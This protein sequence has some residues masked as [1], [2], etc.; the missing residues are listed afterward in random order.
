M[1]YAQTAEEQLQESI[2]SQLEKLDLSAIENYISSLPNIGDGLYKGSFLENIKE[3]INGSKQLDF[4]S[5]F[6]Y[7]INLI[8]DDLLKYVPIF[9]VI[10]AICIVCSLLTGFSPDKNGEKINKVIYFACFAVVAIIIFSVFKD[11]LSLALGILDGIKNQM[12]LVFPILLTLITS[13][14]SVVTVSTF[15]PAVALLSSSIVS[16]ISSVVL[17][18]FLFTFV[19]NIVGHMSDTVKLEKCS[20][21][22]ASL[23]KWIIGT[24]FTVFMTILS[25]QGIIAS[26]TDNISIKT[27]KFALKS[28][29]PV[30]GNFV[31]DGLGFILASGVLIKNA[32]GLTGLL[33]LFGTIIVPLVEIVLFMLGLK[34]VA[35]V[36][37]P[38]GETNMSNFIFSCSKCLNMLIA[39]VVAIGFMYVIS[40]GLLMCTSNIF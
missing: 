12:Q 13:V 19:F 37:E 9:S 22:L 7:I 10:V 16:I 4:N 40:V 27:T 17:P 2:N 28:Y 1:S 23:F 36:V 39:C 15:K 14:G 38:L 32:V 31:S 18:I 33:V 26:V 30:I 21:F 6:S 35:A 11:L 29:I 8:F 24:V 34:L 5:F 20:K 25:L 3:I